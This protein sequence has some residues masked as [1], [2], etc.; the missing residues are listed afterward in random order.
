[1][2]KVASIFFYNGQIEK[3]SSVF[4]KVVSQFESFNKI[5]DARLFIVCQ[6]INR[7]ILE[8]LP[9]NVRI[10]QRY[11]KRFRITNAIFLINL[12]SRSLDVFHPGFIYVR[13][14]AYYPYFYTAINKKYANIFIEV[15]TKLLTEMELMN[16]S[17]SVPNTSLLRE[18]ILQRRYFKKVDGLL[19][20]TDEIGEYEQQFNPHIKTHTIGNGYSGTTNSLKRID[21]DTIDLLFVGS[22]GF[23]WHNIERLL[24]SYDTYIDS[25]GDKDIFKIHIVGMEKNDIKYKINNEN[26]IF[27][28][29]LSNSEDLS[30]IY[31]KAD[32]GV[33]TLGLYKKNMSEAAPL[34]VREYLSYGLPVI[35]GYKDVDLPKDLPFVMQV[36]NS[37]DLID[38]SKIKKFYEDFKRYSS[39]EKVK[40]YCAKNLSWDKKCNEILNFMNS[41]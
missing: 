21:D 39:E 38:F 7:S 35:I 25:T 11:E 23:P 17:K 40:D 37:D 13:D 5:C 24:K 36:E 19:T 29:Y 10:I 16:K 31:Q 6:K 15:N 8:E 27:Y 18:K 3:K 30:R 41:C 20:I 28:G 2:S 33:G 26:V 4:K 34:K 32:I 9:N 12:L 1:M 14:I 22:P